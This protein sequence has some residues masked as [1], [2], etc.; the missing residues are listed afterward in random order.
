MIKYKSQVPLVKEYETRESLN[1]KND[2]TVVSVAVG[3]KLTYKQAHDL[4]TEF[5][6]L[7]RK[8]FLTSFFKTKLSESGHIKIL[9][10]KE[11]KNYYESTQKWRR[12]RLSTFCRKFPKGSFIIHTRNHALNIIDGEIYDGEK[13]TEYGRDRFIT[14]AFEVID[15]KAKLPSYDENDK[16]K[17]K[18]K[19]TRKDKAQVN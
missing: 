8:G 12:C 1:E 9:K 6:R 16:F 3:L 15:T 19:P 13:D 4:L 10:Q 17:P 5:G 18:N 7:P 11:V 2:C 14:S